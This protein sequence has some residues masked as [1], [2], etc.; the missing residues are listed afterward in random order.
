M[1]SL[2]CGRRSAPARCWRASCRRAR[3][4]AARRARSRAASAAALASGW[5]AWRSEVFPDEDDFVGALVDP[6]GR[7]GGG[8]HG[9]G[10]AG[11]S[12]LQIG[13][14]GGTVCYRRSADAGIAGSCGAQV[15]REIS[16]AH[17]AAGWFG[18]DQI[19]APVTETDWIAG[20]G[21]T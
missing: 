8:I 7:P 4:L 5:F 6:K 20:A 13:L 15:H 11:P 10:T 1:R 12:A 9:V 18:H 2:S 16:A 19:T 17:G 21:R 14:A 3:P